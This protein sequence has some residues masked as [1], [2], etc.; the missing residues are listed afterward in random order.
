MRE[1]T[2][3]R[4]FFGFIAAV[5]GIALSAVSIEGLAIL[6][7]TVEDGRY[8]SAAELFERTQNTYVR[9]C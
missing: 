3:R 7:L 2:K 1:K 9:D 6:W 5:I 8:T 4:L